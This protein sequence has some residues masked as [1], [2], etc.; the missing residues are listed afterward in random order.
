MDVFAYAM[1]ME[2]DGE[3]YYRE[4]A[5]KSPDRGLARILTMLADQEVKHFEILQA[6]R[7]GKDAHVE[8]GT[9][10]DDAKNLFQQMADAEASFDFSTPQID[11]YKKAQEIE[12]KSRDFYL[13]KADQAG[14][15]SAK[16]VL[17][18]IAHEEKLHYDILGT[19]VELIS[20]PE[21]GNWLENAE[22]YHTDT[23]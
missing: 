23:Y 9:F 22:W 3:Q 20:R 10:R 5:Q 19:M 11:L 14:S 2:K 7:K 13:E 4:L 12:Q 17:L 6:M 16:E 8:A 18:N 1:Q 15:P 21:P